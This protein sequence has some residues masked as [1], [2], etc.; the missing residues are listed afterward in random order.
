MFGRTI[1]A[2]LRD[3]QL[4]EI[5]RLQCFSLSRFTESQFVIPG[6]KGHDVDT[7]WC[8]YSA[9]LFLFSRKT[10]KKRFIQLTEI[11]AWHNYI[12]RYSTR[13]ST[14]H[15][16]SRRVCLTTYLFS[17]VEREVCSLLWYFYLFRCLCVLN[18]FSGLLFCGFDHRWSM[19]TTHFTVPWE[20]TYGLLLSNFSPTS[21]SCALT[22]L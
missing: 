14:L 8:C 17:P 12:F 4:E 6:Y 9:F 3:H 2:F 10:K 11:D 22:W 5:C 13:W 1:V 15:T 20:L 21:T 16:Y 18:V 7:L 19:V